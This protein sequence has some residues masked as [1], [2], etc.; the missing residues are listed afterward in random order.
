MSKVLSENMCGL[1]LPFLERSGEL[2]AL[3]LLKL[4]DL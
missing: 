1:G 4:A 2:V 3:F